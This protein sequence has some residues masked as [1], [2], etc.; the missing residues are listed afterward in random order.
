MTFTTTFAVN[1]QTPANVIVGTLIPAGMWVYVGPASGP[2]NVAAAHGAGT[3]TTASFVFS[4]GTMSCTVAGIIYPVTATTTAV[5]VPGTKSSGTWAAPTQARLSSQPMRSLGAAATPRHMIADFDDEDDD[6]I[7]NQ[8]VVNPGQ[9]GTVWS[10]GWNVR[11]CGN[12]KA[13]LVK[14]Q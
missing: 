9:T 13:M 1:W 11:V 14:V 10:D 3:V 8:T 2:V 7:V 5:C 4:D 6:R 12:G